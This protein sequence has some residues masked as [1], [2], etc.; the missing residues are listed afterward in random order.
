MRIVADFH[1]HSRYSRATSSQ[2]DLELL[3]RWAKYKGITLLGTGD[4]THPLWLAELKQ[5]L[6]AG[7]GGLYQYQGVL[8][9]LTAEVNAN[10]VSGGKGRRIHNLLLLPSIEVAERLNQRLARYG[11]LAS[12]GRPTLNLSAQEL[13][14][15]ALEVSPEILI[16]PAHAWTPHFSIF[17]ANSGFDTVEECFG[18]QAKEIHCLETGLSSDPA[19]NWRLSQLD[20]YTLIS[21]SDSHSASRIGRE[22]NVFEGQP[23]YGEILSILK[24]KDPKRFLYTIEF[25]PEEGKYHFDGHRLCKARVSPEESA[26]NQNR[27]P[28]CGKKV[29]IGVMHRVESL[30]NRPIGYEP[31]PPHRIPFKNLVPLD[32]IIADV[33]S[34]GVGSKAVEQEYLEWVQRVGSEFEI[35][36]D[37]SEEALRKQ[38]PPKVAEGILRVRRGEIRILPGYDGEYG[39]VNIFGQE[40]PQMGEKQLTLFE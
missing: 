31:P 15:L 29:T 35:L 23:G 1:I 6:K 30:A 22:A 36:V 14:K 25:F 40:E 20:R 24:G 32:Q 17:G 8:F 4:C 18:P 28:V 5:K 34:V 27:C 13:V 16:V 2:L 26:K 11:D 33:R 3:A 9:L 12:D 7:P 38:L 10:F 39:E 19:M 21:N 37:L